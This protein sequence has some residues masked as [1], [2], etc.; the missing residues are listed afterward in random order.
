MPPSSPRA[1]SEQDR[2]GR[3]DRAVPS[4]STLSGRAITEAACH[5]GDG[6]QARLHGCRRWLRHPVEDRQFGW[7][8]GWASARDDRALFACAPSVAV[9]RGARAGQCDP[10]NEK[11][12]GGADSD[13][14]PTDAAGVADDAHDCRRRSVAAGAARADL[15]AWSGV[16]RRCR[17]LLVGIWLNEG[18][19]VGRSDRGFGPG[20]R[21]RVGRRGGRQACRE[22]K[23]E[24]DRGC[25]A[26]LADHFHSSRCWSPC[27]TGRGEASRPMV[28]GR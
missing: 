14:S 8:V 13:V 26:V 1:G 15:R 21:C 25:D 2:A 16:G 5:P 4:N 28:V 18:A 22:C 12:H 27:A 23:R 19:A 9:C 11:T 3:V 10:D 6:E 7:L 17:A 20:E 24:H